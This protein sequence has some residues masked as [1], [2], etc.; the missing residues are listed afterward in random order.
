MTPVCTALPTEIARAYRAGAPDAN[1]MP[2]ERAVSDGGDNPCRHCLR[3]IPEGAPMLILAHRPFPAPQPYAELG[4]I[5]LCAGPCE[6]WEGEGLPPIATAPDYIVRGYTDADRIRYG[7]GA[8][9]RTADLP[10]RA[11][12]LLGRD[13][14]AY[15]HVRSAR[16]NCYQ[17]RI[18]RG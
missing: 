14:I 13:D 8:V 4:P 7:T 1:G 3:H 15:L 11:R 17:F 12:E 2:P 5:F 9:V 6:R 10:A 18:D 16:N